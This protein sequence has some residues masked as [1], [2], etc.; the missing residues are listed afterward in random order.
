MKC[1]GM[2]QHKTKEEKKQK[3]ERAR[4]GQNVT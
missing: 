1:N 3:E 2:T 4:M